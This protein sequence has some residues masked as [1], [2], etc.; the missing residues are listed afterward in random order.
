MLFLY[1]I[2]MQIVIDNKSKF[3]EKYNERIKSIKESDEKTL[4][5][6]QAKLREREQREKR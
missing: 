1:I 5:R 3:A 2:W 4:M 6:K